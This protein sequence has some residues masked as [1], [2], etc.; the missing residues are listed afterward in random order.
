MKLILCILAG[1]ILMGHANLG[2]QNSGGSTV[3]VAIAK[4]A[5]TGSRG[6]LELSKGPDALERGGL[7]ELLKE[8]GCQFAGSRAAQL[9]PE[10]DKQYG[11]WNRMGLA[12][13][14]LGR[15]VAKNLREGTF[16]LGLLANCSSLLGMLAG[17]QHSG[18]GVSPLKVGLVWIDAHADFNTPETTLSGMLGGMPVAT[19]AGLCLTRLRLQSG[20]DP[21]LPYSYITMIGVRDMDPLEQELVDR[22]R[23]ERIPVGDI[24]GPYSRIHDQM[25]RLSEVTDRIYVHIDMDV[26]DPAEVSGHPLTVPSGPKSHDLGGALETM[27][28]YEKACALGIASYPWENDKGLLSLKAAY[29]LVEGS[30][31]GV[32]AARMAPQRA[33]ST[34]GS[35]QSLLRK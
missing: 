8:S 22:Y 34:P 3:N 23:I 1:F 20:L 35:P 29:A 12:N 32:K 24:H 9:T 25:K 19:A 31:R 33:T 28:R 14:H 26:L 27:F 18:P 13:N 21:A 15:I 11:A 10:E 6:E 16:P 4:N 7:V 5:F 30:L 17:V 2:A